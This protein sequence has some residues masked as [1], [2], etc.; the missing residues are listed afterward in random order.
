MNDTAEAVTTQDAGVTECRGQIHRTS[1]F[2]RRERQRSMR[3]VP[4]VVINE[5]P[6]DPLKVR[7][8]QDKEPVEALPTGGAHKPLGNR[9]G[10]GRAKRCP[11]DRNRSLRKTSSNRSVNFLIPITNQKPD[12]FR[13]VRQR[14]RHVPR[15][16]ADPIRQS[17]SPCTRPSA[18]GGC[19][20]R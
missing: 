12:R 1:A 17:D 4:V 5:R 13:T 11:N 18:R 9:V 20:T 8:V 15:L 2:R 6:K 16:L 7:L 14:P 10:L 3:P 19:L